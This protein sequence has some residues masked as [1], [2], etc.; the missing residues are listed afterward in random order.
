MK[1]REV[2]AE[3]WIAHRKERKKIASAKWYAAKKKREQQRQR[4]KRQ[5]L[6]AELAAKQ[7]ANNRYIWKTAEERASWRCVV[8][9]LRRG[10]P[11]RPSHIAALD[12]CEIIDLAD[13][14]IQRMGIDWSGRPPQH[15]ATVRELCVRE[16]RDCYESGGGLPR[17]RERIRSRSS[18]VAHHNV[19]SRASNSA[20]ESMASWLTGGWFP[21]VC[22]GVGCVFLQLAVLGQLRLWPGLV[23][24]MYRVQ[25]ATTTTDQQNGD[26]PP[27]TSPPHQ[28]PMQSPCLNDPVIQ[29]MLREFTTTQQQQEDLQ[30]Q[31]TEEE[32]T[33]SSSSSHSSYFSCS[34]PSSL[35]TFFDL[36]TST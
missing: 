2:T 6:E 11:C 4:L 1:R 26:N 29:A 28:N 7:E 15:L 27:H 36:P 24:Q 9:H 5:Q 31:Q 34:L 10:W 21:F 12:W 32:D 3:V 30:Q 16:L 22:T 8:D 14:C 35:D 13:E 19:D 23:H 17:I 20:W 33:A 18:A 25:Q